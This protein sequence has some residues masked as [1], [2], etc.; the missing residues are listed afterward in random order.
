MFGIALGT[1][2]YIRRDIVI[3][4]LHKYFYWKGVKHKEPNAIH[5]GVWDQVYSKERGRS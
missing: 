5:N 3:L 1:G 2:M 4:I